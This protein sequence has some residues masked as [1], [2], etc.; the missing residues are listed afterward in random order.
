MFETGVYCESLKS[1]LNIS[2]SVKHE[3]ITVYVIQAQLG[4]D[5]HDAKMV[6]MIML[7]L[8][9]LTFYQLAAYFTCLEL[10]LVYF[11]FVYP[12]LL[13]D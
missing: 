2:H 3:M 10:M 8:M 12:F 7:T 5:A 13:M 6:Y 1:D 11:A 9:T 4:V